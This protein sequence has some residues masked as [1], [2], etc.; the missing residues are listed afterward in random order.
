VL[1]A[2]QDIPEANVS[3][4]IGDVPLEIVQLQG[5]MI[6]RIKVFRPSG[7]SPSAEEAQ[8]AQRVETEE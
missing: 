1:E 3:L 2:L 8:T 7:P 6:R 5:R 4:K